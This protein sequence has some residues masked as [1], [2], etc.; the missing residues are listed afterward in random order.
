MDGQQRPV[1]AVVFDVDG[2]LVHAGEFGKLLESRYGIDR[3]VQSGFFQGPFREC[4]R[5]RA[6][7]REVIGP[8][9]Q[10]WNWPGTVDDFLRV[11]FEA[12]S[13]VDQG[14][15]DVASRLRAD[16]YACY[17]ASTQ[18]RHRAAYLRDVV[19]LGARFDELFFSWEVGV[20]KGDP[21][22][23]ELV[24]VQIGLAPERILFFDDVDGIVETARGVG[25]K[26]EVYAS[27]DDMWELLAR[28]GVRPSDV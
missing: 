12:D 10:E 8:F 13:E 27:G 16:G 19:G 9:L 22:F 23:F 26:A 25:W 4:V 28:H 7:L 1:D 18:E 11:W 2:V 15:L 17:V 21:M 6:D 24:T 5:G 20:T 3:E 14:S